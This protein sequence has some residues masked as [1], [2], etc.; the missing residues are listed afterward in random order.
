[1]PKPIMGKG[2]YMAGL[3][4]LRAL[5]VLA[6]VAYHLQFEWIPGGLLGVGVFFVL[7]GYLITDLLVM[8]WKRNGR[9]DLAD[10]WLRRARRL[11]PAMF[12]LL[13]AV[14][15]WLL[16]REPSRLIA[17]REE[18]LAS[19]LYV[20]NWWLIF[21]EVSY[22]ESFGPPSPLGHFWSLAVEEQFY[23]LWPLLLMA[24]IRLFRKRGMLFAVTTGA[25]LLSACLMVLLYEPGVDPSRVYYGTDTRA[26]GLLIGAA[27]AMVWPSA[28]LSDRV[29][30]R[31]RWS[32]DLVGAVG[33]AILLGMFWKINEYDP[34]LYQGGFVILSLV[35]AIVVAVLAHPATRLGKFMGAAPFRWIG[36]RS[37]G[38]YLWHYPVIVLTSPAVNTSGVNLSL[39]LMQLAASVILADLS[40]RFVEEPIRRGTWKRLWE[41]VRPGQGRRSRAAWL[42]T[43]AA[44]VIGL[45]FA[46]MSQLYPIA[47]ASTYTDDD[48]P[49]HPSG[50]HPATEQASRQEQ[51]QGASRAGEMP[52]GANGA[53]DPA[54]PAGTPGASG[55]AG[56]SHQTTGSTSATAGTAVRG[57]GKGIT[58]IGDSVMLGAEPSLKEMLPG[59]TIDGK[60]GRQWSHALEIIKR[61]K[62]EGKLGQTVV[63]ELGSNGPFTVKQMDAILEALGEKRQIILVNTRVPRPWE[64]EVNA[65]LKQRADS[66]KAIS[67]IDWY[68]ASTGK[69]HYFAKDG[70]HLTVEGAK[71]Y[72]DL[73]TSGILSRMQDH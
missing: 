43:A 15:A 20:S 58:V 71:A 6:V 59:I 8:E 52:P 18:L 53:T 21:H 3:D 17:I 7:S 36:L 45:V 38:I 4:G 27:L 34:F 26:F 2:R 67:L 22:F 39:S 65:G 56:A 28:K 40:W 23:L 25:A 66:S 37:Y 57:S 61:L 63:L 64:R 14:I 51:H 31:G 49:D 9:I 29:S 11:L 33:M 32:L 69:D 42:T 35:T 10:F 48:G 44:A 46:G 19:L 13:A 54:G 60:I 47:T 1:M 70:V 73:L 5:A 41:R 68:G 55:P 50:N 62:A 30:P 24:G 12:V 72:A 16:I